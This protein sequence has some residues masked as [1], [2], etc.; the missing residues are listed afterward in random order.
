MPWSAGDRLRGTRGQPKPNRKPVKRQM[1]G[2]DRRQKS[3]KSIFHFPV[4]LPLD[5]V[6]VCACVCGCARVGRGQH[7]KNTGENV[8]EKT[9]PLMKVLDRRRFMRYLP[10]VWFRWNGGRMLPQLECTNS[11]SPSVCVCVQPLEAQINAPQARLSSEGVLH[12]NKIQLGRRPLP[13]K[14]R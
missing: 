3:R 7:L 5:G 8:N 11:H 1:G 10:N 4:P 2:S 9:L 13:F 6:F 14:G 12:R